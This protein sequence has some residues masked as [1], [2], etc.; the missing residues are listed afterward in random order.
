MQIGKMV[1]TGISSRFRKMNSFV[2]NC[3]PAYIM[4]K[5]T[6]SQ[7]LRTL[8]I[9]KWK[10]YSDLNGILYLHT[11]ESEK[12]SQRLIKCTLLVPDLPRLDMAKIILSQWRIR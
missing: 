2:L 12:D 3:M 1:Q 4:G 11:I 5:I 9:G 10:C 7:F 6:F 8:R